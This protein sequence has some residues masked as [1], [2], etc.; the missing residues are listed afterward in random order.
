MIV[1]ITM[2]RNELHLVK[3]LLPIWKTYSDGFVFLLHNNT[4]ETKNYLNSVKSEYNILNILEVNDDNECPIET[5][6]R[7]LLFD[8]AIKYSKNII[9]L[10]A[11][12]YLDGKLEKYELENLL[13]YNPNT[14]FHLHWIQYTSINTIRVDGPWKFNLKDRIGNFYD[15]S[16]FVKTQKHSTHLPPN[17]VNKIIEKNDLFIAH[18]H[19]LNKTYAAIKQY[20]WKVDDYINNKKF[21]VDV[22]GNTAY[23]D[24]VNNFNWEEEYTFDI[25]K[26]SPWII[27]NITIENNYRIP[28]LQNNIKLYEVPDLGSWG[29]DFKNVDKININKNKYKVSVITA[30]G[31]LKTYEKFIPRW[32]SNVTEQ[33]F[34]KQTEHIIVYKDWSNYFDSM[35]ELDNF[36][37]IKEDESNGMYYAWNIGIKNSTTD[38]VTNWNVDD[39]RHPINTKI[40]FDL[41]ER[42]NDIDLV[43]NWYVATLCEDDNFYNIDFSKKSVLMYPDNFHTLA[44]QNCYAG[45]DPMWRK[46]LHTLA[47][48]FDYKNFSVIGDWDM[49]IRFAKNGSTFKLIPEVLCIYLDHSNTVSN[50]NNSSIDEQKIKLYKKYYEYK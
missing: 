39:L 47:G 17:L 21:G 30:I 36:K 32:I 8:E 50:S 9:C 11:D 13:E 2:V 14:T 3:E 42:N 41:L 7:Q 4:D 34:F 6:L 16:L 12:E 35:Q 28:I 25:L 18:L 45:P 31:D 5:N 23:D 22:V 43:Y 49:W 19:W 20:Y 44:L 1:Q 40:K 29:Y 24:S 15:N 38:Y 26:V 37:L 10:D 33:H 46:S 27:D 48:Y